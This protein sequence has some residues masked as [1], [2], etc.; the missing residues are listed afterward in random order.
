M[1]NFNF[2]GLRFVWMYLIKYKLERQTDK[3]SHE[4]SQYCISFIVLE[5]SGWF[6]VWI[7]FDIFY[8]D[9]QEL[10]KEKHFFHELSEMQIYFQSSV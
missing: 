5:P 1:A 3:I 8:Y 4:L 2:V 9:L 6:L 10:R 7:S